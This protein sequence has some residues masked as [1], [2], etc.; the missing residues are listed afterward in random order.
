[1]ERSEGVT[2]PYEYFLIDPN[3]DF[4]IDPDGNFLTAYFEDTVYPQVLN[5][6]ADDFTLNTE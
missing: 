1:L 5:T 2:Y 6:T 4:L 3:G